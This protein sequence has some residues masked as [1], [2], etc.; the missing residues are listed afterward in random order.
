M[1]KFVKMKKMTFQAGM[2]VLM[3][4]SFG[5]AA[6][7][8]E[9]ALKLSLKEAIKLAAEKN[10]DVQ[11]ELYNP[12]ISEADLR[13]STAIYDPFLNLLTSYGVTTTTNPTLLAANISKSKIFDANAGISQL[14]PYGG[15]VGLSFESSWNKSSFPN[16]PDPSLSNKDIFQNTLSVNVSQP[17]LKNFG[18]DTTELNISLAKYNKDASLDQFRTR[19][20]A[21][22]AQVR[23]EYF[24]LYSLRE[25]LEVKKTS[26]ALAQKILDETNARVKSGV[27]P[28][29]EILNAEFNVAT[30]ERD[31]I[32]AERALSDERDVLRT[33]LQVDAPGGIDLVDSP[34]TE[35]Y[36]ISE[37][38][39]IRQAL[40]TRPELKQLRE[41]QR[42]ADLLER[43]AHHQILPDLSLNASG[44][45][46]GI[47][48]QYDK[49]WSKLFS[50]D[51]PVWGVGL[52][53]S[54]PLGNT[55]AK[56]DYIRSKLKSEQLRIQIR[57]QEE[58]II[59]EVR[60]AIRAVQSG[61]KQIDVTNRGSAYAEEVLKAYI[62][63]SEVGLATT[64]DVFDVQNNLVAAKGAQILA[65]AGYDAALTQFWKAT[66]EILE[67]EGITINGKEADELYRRVR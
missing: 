52:T 59:N 2:A 37:E 40:E 1:N 41:N 49:Q 27:L 11:V 38:E 30:R 20:T 22:I 6:P 61:Y 4:L 12:A 8:Q 14:T 54:Y 34:F 55:S 65:K 26:L 21:V 33:L 3:T 67:R 46:S 28:A 24:K 44:G 35:P 7:A 64:K 19:L 58:A 15:T 62:K 25:D 63:K 13:Q 45:L 23:S 16:S 18:R 56:N 17:L 10:L 53:F 39:A 29:M 42:S 9:G 57:R 32:Q 51:Y 50:A 48:N 36:P 60:S 47:S 5:A 31:I 43:V 66:A